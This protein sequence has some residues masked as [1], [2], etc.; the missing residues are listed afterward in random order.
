MSTESKM[1]EKANTVFR[2]KGYL[3]QKSEFVN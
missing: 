2:S 1:E 3:Y